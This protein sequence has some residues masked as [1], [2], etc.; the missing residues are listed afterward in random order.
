MNIHNEKQKGGE[1]QEKDFNKAVGFKSDLCKQASWHD[2]KY[3]SIPHKWEKSGESEKRD[4]PYLASCT[5]LPATALRGCNFIQ[6][7]QPMS[8]LTLS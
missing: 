7:P 3:E 6:G 1:F 2:G 5:H 8:H 4:A